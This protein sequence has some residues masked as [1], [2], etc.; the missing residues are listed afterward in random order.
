MSQFALQLFL[1]EVRIIR[2]TQAVIPE[3]AYYPP[4]SNL[5]NRIG[6]TFKP[7]VRAVM[8]LKNMGAGLP[9]GGLF[10]QDQFDLE[11]K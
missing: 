9:D 3:T 6:A 7:K 1:D 11:N 2:G 4:L 5:F 10:T 8:I